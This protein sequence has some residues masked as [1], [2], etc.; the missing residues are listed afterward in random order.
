MKK[1]IL[2]IGFILL[3]LSLFAQEQKETMPPDKIASDRP[4]Q[5]LNGM[6][7]ASGAAQIQTGFASGFGSFFSTNSLH[8]LRIGI[9]DQLEINGGIGLYIDEDAYE[10]TGFSVGARY[11][12]LRKEGAL[13]SIQASAGFPPFLRFDTQWERVQYSGTI[14]I[15]HPLGEHIYLTV[16]LGSSSGIWQQEFGM[17][18]TLNLAAPIGD[19]WE[20]FIEYFDTYT[21]RTS[22][23]S[24]FDAGL[25]YYIGTNGKVDLS[26]GILNAFESEVRNSFIDLG[27]SWVFR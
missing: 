5:S 18:G 22:L 25:G 24:S 20:V 11:N 7:I 6:T 12:I 21:E 23:N 15:G 19:R 26:L 17:F 13:L 1:A 9:S 8:Q 3:A 4:G 16:N 27:I 10:L 14:I 2:S